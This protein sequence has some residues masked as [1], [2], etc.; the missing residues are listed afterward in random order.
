MYTMAY[1]LSGMM[2]A[3]AGARHGCGPPWSMY[4]S[5]VARVMD[6]GA[7]AASVHSVR[8]ICGLG[9]LSP[10]APAAHAQAGRVAGPQM[11]G[12]V[13]LRAQALV[14]HQ[15]EATA[16]AFRTLCDS[17][18]SAFRPPENDNDVA[19]VFDRTA[20]RVCL[21]LLSPEQLLAAELHYHLQRSQ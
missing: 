1:G 10:A 18:R 20:S 15:L 11:A 7:G 9:G 12:P 14:Q 3:C 8:G 19:T 17:L 16:K 4:W 6:L 2:L 5:M 21:L 13:D